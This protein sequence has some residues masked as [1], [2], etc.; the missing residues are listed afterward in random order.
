MSQYFVT[1]NQRGVGADYDHSVIWVTVLLLALGLVMV[2]SASIASAEASRATGNNT[3]YYLIRHAM[4]VLV[5]LFA[6]A[7]VFQVPIRVWQPAAPFL[8]L[9][10][11]GLLALVLVPRPTTRCARRRSCTACARA[12]CRCS[13]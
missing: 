3:M 9:A 1:M 6:A 4:F 8:L 2:Y 7:M 10:G 11:L 12:S 13:V 5:S